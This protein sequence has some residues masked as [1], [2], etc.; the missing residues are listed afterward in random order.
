MTERQVFEAICRQMYVSVGGMMKAVPMAIAFALFSAG[1]TY[2][3][4]SIC[5]ANYKKKMNLVF[6]ISYIAFLIHM[7]IIS[8]I[9]MKHIEIDIIPFNTPGGWYLVLI[10]ALAN[11]IVFV[12]L[13]IILTNMFTMKKIKEIS[14]YGMT[15]SIF[16]ELAQLLSKRGVCQLEDVI[17]NTLGVAIGCIIYRIMENKKRGKHESTE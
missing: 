6:G 2:V 14:L 11:C 3:I 8:R 17:M 7:T 16:I 12:P 4:M 15:V 5:C 10:Y 1:I 13:G 9:T